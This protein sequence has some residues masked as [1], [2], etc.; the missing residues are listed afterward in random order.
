MKKI[1]SNWSITI[2]I[3]LIIQFSLW[4]YTSLVNKSIDISYKANNHIVYFEQ[5]PKLFLVIEVVSIIG[6]LYTIYLATKFIKCKRYNKNEETNN[7][8]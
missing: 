1:C 4:I 7:L 2:I 6:I 8:P 5:E 3:I